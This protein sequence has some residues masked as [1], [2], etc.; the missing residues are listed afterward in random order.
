MHTHGNGH[1]ALLVPIGTPGILLQ[2]GSV[3]IMR[4]ITWDCIAGKYTAQ[5]FWM[6]INFLQRMHCRL[7]WANLRCDCARG[8]WFAAA[9]GL[10]LTP[11][12]QRID[13]T[14]AVLAAAKRPV[15]GGMATKHARMEQHSREAPRLNKGVPL[16]RACTACM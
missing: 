10:P 8:P 1:Q 16:P 3:L 7:P 14:S 2:A 5:F 12:A 11:T 6:E 13:L 4:E 9:G 15:D